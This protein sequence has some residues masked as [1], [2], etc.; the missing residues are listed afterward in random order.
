[1]P[2]RASYDFIP[3]TNND[4][5]EPMDV[6]NPEHQKEILLAAQL[7]RI[8]CRQLEVDGYRALQNTL[9]ANKWDKS[10]FEFVFQLGQ[11]LLALRVS[12]WEVLGDG[13][14]KPDITK[15]QYEDRVSSL[16]R[17]LF[18]Y[19]MSMKMKMVKMK[20]S[21]PMNPD[22]AQSH[23]A[24]AA[25]VWDDFPRQATNE[26]YEDWMARGKELIHEDGRNQS[27][28][29]DCARACDGQQGHYKGS[30]PMPATEA[31]SAVGLSTAAPAKPKNTRSFNGKLAVIF[32]SL[33]T[34]ANVHPC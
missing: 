25:P 28:Q 14:K 10:P 9:N 13:S 20:L 11:I 3:V 7:S 2:S 31:P 18:F 6:C 5:A 33:T 34:F 24:D 17:V 8:F 21:S 32:P 30:S 12:W 4:S 23:Y 1:M 27:S 16:C 26:G 15:K 22:S 29:L 19:Y